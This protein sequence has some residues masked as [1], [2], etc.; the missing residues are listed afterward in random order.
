MGRFLTSFL[1]YF[2]ETIR[3]APKGTYKVQ[4]M[5]TKTADDLVAGGE[6]GIFTPA[7]FWLAR[8]PG[9]GDKKQASN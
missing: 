3:V 8:K 9:K 2:L 5:L 1:T 4:T 6:L 7:Y